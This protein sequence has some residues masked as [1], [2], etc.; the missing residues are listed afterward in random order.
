MLK[1]NRFQRDLFTDLRDRRWSNLSND[2][3]ISERRNP[4]KNFSDRVHVSYKRSHSLDIQ[5]IR[6]K[7]WIQEIS[8]ETKNIFVEWT[9]S[10]SL[11][12]KH[13]RGS[14]ENWREITWETL[15]HSAWQVI[16][17][18]MDWW[19][20]NC[21]SIFFLSSEIHK[22]TLVGFRR[23][24]QKNSWKELLTLLI[25]FWTIFKPSF[26]KSVLTT[27]TCRF[28]RNTSIRVPYCLFSKSFSKGIKKLIFGEE[29]LEEICRNF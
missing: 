6:K 10:L 14:H 20:V 1:F 2:F 11:L 8:E 25:A 15:G 5:I 7:F 21:A 29:I 13:Q 19:K 28:S 27:P 24:S 23:V 9:L 22:I 17:K 26:D 16:G 3:K 4:R 12:N 18:S